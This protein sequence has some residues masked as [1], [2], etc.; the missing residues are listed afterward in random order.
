[1]ENKKWYAVVRLDDCADWGT[2]SYALEEAKEIAE[3]NGPDYYIAV[4]EE[5]AD[6]IC[7]E[8]INRAYRIKPEFADQ[9]FTYWDG[10]EEDLIIDQRELQRLA[11]E[12]GKPLYKLLDQV[13]AAGWIE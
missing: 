3:A 9:W 1:M 4:I 6:P 2:G 10:D 11:G 5:G 8:E 13:E 12:W 7:T